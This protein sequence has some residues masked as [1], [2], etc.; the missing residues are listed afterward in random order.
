MREALAALLQ[1][2]NIDG[3][4]G[5]FD[6]T[7]INT[8]FGMILAE[9]V[10]VLTNLG[11]NVLFDTILPDGSLTRKPGLLTFHKDRRFGTYTYGTQMAQKR[12]SKRAGNMGIKGN[13]KQ[14]TRNC[15]IIGESQ[16]LPVQISTGGSWRHRELQMLTARQISEQQNARARFVCS[17]KRGNVP[18]CASDDYVRF[19]REMAEMG[20][21]TREDIFRFLKFYGMM[22]GNRSMSKG[23]GIFIQQ[24]KGSD[25]A[26]IRE[27]L[28]WLGVEDWLGEWQQERG[29]MRWEITRETYPAL[30]DFW[31]RYHGAYYRNIARMI[32]VEYISTP[33]SSKDAIPRHVINSLDKIQARM[34][35]IGLH[36]ADGLN[37]SGKPKLY[38]ASRL[39]KES[40]TSLCLHAGY[41]VCC[42][43]MRQKAR[44][45]YFI[46]DQ[47]QTIDARTYNNLDY[48]Q[49]ENYKLFKEN[50]PPWVLSFSYQ[51]TAKPVMDT[52][53][54]R[55]T[56]ARPVGVAP[57]PCWTLVRGSKPQRCIIQTVK[58]IVYNNKIVNFFSSTPQV[59]YDHTG[60]VLGVEAQL[61]FRQAFD[62]L[63]HTVVRV[64]DN[65]PLVERDF[66]DDCQVPD[67]IIYGVHQVQANVDQDESGDDSD[68]DDNMHNGGGALPNQGGRAQASSDSDSDSGDNGRGNFGDR[69]GGANG[70][71]NNDESEQNI[72][73]SDGERDE[74]GARARVWRGGQERALQRNQ[75]SSGDDTDSDAG[76]MQRVKRRRNV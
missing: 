75:W 49:K 3:N 61:Q 46:H 44:S 43:C 32:N 24:H 14:S 42:C 41:A 54:M 9:Q 58:K 65:N 60:H 71:R 47:R 2:N 37:K 56:P 19:M 26:Y 18:N 76:V 16:K 39:Y 30:V 53:C 17:V 38:M 23:G 51:R 34:L 25:I 55:Y 29:N 21:N 68:S 1:L 22:L 4:V 57:R 64:K 62:G 10:R 27:T 6:D 12:M 15:G 13:F 48:E 74:Q 67:N 5:L 73:N 45:Y 69:R 7:A 70:Q 52:Q 36:Q 8:N 28:R 35:L 50:Y 63:T 11:Y 40:L 66:D 33:S 31:I 72:G 20:F 59:M